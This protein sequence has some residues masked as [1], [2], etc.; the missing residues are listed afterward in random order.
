MCLTFC[1][2]KMD[3]FEYL[4]SDF[5]ISKNNKKI[6]KRAWDGR[7]NVVLKKI[8]TNG[9]HIWRFS[10]PKYKF[11]NSDTLI[12]IIKDFDENPG[13]SRVYKICNIPNEHGAFTVNHSHNTFAFG[14]QGK[15]FHG[16]R[17]NEYGI[18]CEGGA[19][20][21]MILDLDK[22]LLKYIINGQDCEVGFEVASG[23]YRAI[24]SV[25]KAGDCIE[26]I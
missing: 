2:W 17:G 26:I 20:I 12:G 15:K 14:L 22:N 23:K 4:S 11:K 18:K 16:S 9:Y 7:S 10:I 6:I 21:E 13:F 8:I 1:G 25:H 24:V 5:K 3:E 19:I